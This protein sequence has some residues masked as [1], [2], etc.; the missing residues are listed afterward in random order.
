MNETDRAR[1]ASI[2]EATVEAGGYVMF[3]HP[4][5]ADAGLFTVEWW[6]PGLDE[7]CWTE[8]RHEEL[9]DALRE[10]TGR[11]GIDGPSGNGAGK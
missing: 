3:A 7:P 8:G 5:A 9:S 4:T 10:V 2:V 11:L 1:I 6:H